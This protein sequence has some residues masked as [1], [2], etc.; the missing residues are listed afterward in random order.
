MDGHDRTGMGTTASVAVAL[1][2]S[3]AALLAGG[4]RRGATPAP[5]AGEASAPRAAQPAPLVPADPRQQ[6]LQRVDLLI[7]QWDAS[8]AEGPA[9]QTQAI[10]DRIRQEVDAAYGD[11]AEAAKGAKGIRLHYLGVAA[12]GF[13]ARREATQVLVEQLIHDDPR[14]V[15]NAL[16]ALKMR[17]DP[18]TPLPPILQ[19]IPGGAPEPKRYAPLALANV[20]E[21]RQRA[22]RP[23]DA[24]AE[25]T[26]MNL[27]SGVVADRDPYV[28]LHVAK[29]LGFLPQP[30]S[31]ELV[32]V[33]M[34]DEHVRIRVAAAAALERLGDPRGFVDVIKLLADAPDETKPVVRDLL[35]SY[36]GRLQGAPLPDA[37]DN[38]FGTSAASWHRSYQDYAQRTGLALPS[39]AATVPANAP[40]QP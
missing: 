18:D 5:E 3:L 19:R 6:T 30:G 11:F 20:L 35:G 38:E 7:A 12:L 13:S 37:Q 24:A 1:A 25:R 29:A 4:C 9:E 32:Q 39:A 10:F 26:A 28:R 23:R 17:A 27:L 22:G 16:V 36:A 15:G 31:F 14:L 34:K 8:Q 40:K 21:A 2:L 33:L